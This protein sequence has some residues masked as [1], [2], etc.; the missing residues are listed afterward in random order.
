[1]VKRK[2]K[3]GHGNFKSWLDENVEFTARTARRYMDLF[4]YRELLKSDN[5]SDLTTGAK[6]IKSAK[7]ANRLAKATVAKKLLGRGS[8][9][10]KARP[11]RSDNIDETSEDTAKL[12]E[13]APGPDTSAQAR[14]PE[15]RTRAINA[16]CGQPLLISKQDAC[17][18]VDAAEGDT[19]AHIYRSA[20]RLH[21][22][23]KLPGQMSKLQTDKE[24]EDQQTMKRTTVKEL[25][26]GI[27]EDALD[28]KALEPERAE[29]LA[30]IKEGRELNR[31]LADQ[32]KPA[33][34]LVHTLWFRPGLKKTRPDHKHS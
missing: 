30:L 4:L 21:G 10:P 22:Q 20:L 7:F 3:C 34:D 26:D 18:L 17:K 23:A 28:G 27:V 15:L 9:K 5:V 2:G 29:L 14:D 11:D 24:G 31:A 12:Q 25:F 16:L 13:S 32:L 1:L 8:E 33:R 19:E 6:V